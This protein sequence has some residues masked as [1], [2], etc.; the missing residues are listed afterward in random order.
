MKNAN[1]LICATLLSST[2]STQQV[3]CSQPGTAENHTK[4]NFLIIMADDLGYGD[5]SCSWRRN[6]DTAVSAR[7]TNALGDITGIRTPLQNQISYKPDPARRGHNLWDPMGLAGYFFDGTGNHPEP[8]DIDGSPNFKTDVR[9]LWEAYKD[10]A[11]YAHGIGSGYTADG[12]PHKGKGKRL[13]ILTKAAFGESMEEQ[14]D[15]MI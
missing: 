11:F 5:I 3:T 7:S 1:S 9:L 8:K 10:K 6:A 4:P 12:K 2:L 14:V 15:W 13:R